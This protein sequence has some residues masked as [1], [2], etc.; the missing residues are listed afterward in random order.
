M[1]KLLLLISGFSLS[2]NLLAQERLLPPK[3]SPF[4]KTETKIGIVEMSLEY[5]RPSMRGRKIFG[6]LVE[7]GK[8]WRTGANLNTK[9]SFKEKVQI[10]D[11][12]L[13]AGAYTLFTKPNPDS[14]EVYFYSL[15][16]EYGAP[17]TL[18]SK[19]VVAQ[20]TVPV[21]K[22]KRD[23]ETL[24]ISFDNLTSN[25]VTLGIAWERS[26]IP[27]PIKIPTDEIMQDKFLMA[28]IALAGDY[29]SKGKI[30]ASLWNT[31]TL[32]DQYYFQPPCP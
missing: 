4:Q 6:G 14:W 25:S 5:S 10:G 13:E 17:E 18:D 26:Y 9:V 22:L 24:S 7:Y 3:P 27:V 15:L 12:K 11:Y 29:E 19:N 30:T 28:N 16:E 1:Y 20:I 21:V 32:D 31:D 23:I 8:I 2:A